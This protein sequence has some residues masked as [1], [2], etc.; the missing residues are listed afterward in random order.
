[1][2]IV[3]RLRK[4]HSRLQRKRIL[5]LEYV[6]SHVYRKRYLKWLKRQG[7]I[8]HGTPNYI[9]NTAYFD[10]S[11]FSMIEL[12]DGCTISREVMFLTHDYSIHTVLVGLSDTLCE[13]TN[14]R[15]KAWDQ[16]N[17]ALIQRKIIV[18]D[19][20]FIGARAS[21]LPGTRIG[22]NCIVG[23]GAVVRGN[24][25]DNT[26]VTGNPAVF[27]KLTSDWLDEKANKVKIY[28]GK[29]NNNG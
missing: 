8:I 17:N 11:D 6:N 20:S 28:D 25:P 5:R 12:G 14:S 4:I 15:L 3:D 16:C 9:S 21:L 13:E 2:N 22:N 27:Y 18:G 7:V 10:G 26:I 24:V 19:H 29:E 23:A 1:M